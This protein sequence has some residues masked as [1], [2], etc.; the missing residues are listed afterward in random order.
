MLPITWLANIVSAGKASNISF[1]LHS[2]F[3]FSTA[4]CFRRI[5]VARLHVLNLTLVP[6]YV[7]Q[8]FKFSQV[9]PFTVKGITA[10]K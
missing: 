5:L 4:L 6:A 8:W 3:R 7:K 10:Q 2:V 1:R 9:L